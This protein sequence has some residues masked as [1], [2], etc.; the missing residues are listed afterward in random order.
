MSDERRRQC[1]TE[2]DAERIATAAA[3]K[4]LES[5]YEETLKKV[6]A[7][8]GRGVVNKMFVVIGAAIV[9]GLA[10]AKAKGWL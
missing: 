9:A 3:T 10:Y 1:I 8:I 2:E 7:D 4:A 6:Y 5:V